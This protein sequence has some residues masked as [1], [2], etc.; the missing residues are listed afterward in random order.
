MG[1]EPLDNYKETGRVT[2]ENAR[3]AILH[4]GASNLA[5]NSSLGVVDFTALLRRNHIPGWDI[6]DAHQRHAISFL[7]KQ[8][9]HLDSVMQR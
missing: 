4:I 2:W 1:I 5:P 3:S 9:G 8:E 7:R 6:C